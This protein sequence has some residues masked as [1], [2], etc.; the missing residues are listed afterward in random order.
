MPLDLDSLNEKQRAAV[1][2]LDGPLLVLAGAGSGKTRTLTYR[3]AYLLEQGRASPHSILAITFTRKAAAELAHRLES[4]VGESAKDITA[5]TFHGLGYRLLRAEAHVFG[6]K[7]D[8][9]TVYDATDARR[10]LL[11]AMKDTNVAGERWDLEMVAQTISSAKEQLRSPEEFITTEGDFFEE[12]VGKVY[13][14]YQDLLKENNAVDY[15]DLIRLTLSLLQQRPEA[16]AFYQNLFRYVS[17]DELQDTSAAQYELVRYLGWAHH[18]VCAVGSPMQAIYS[19][20]GGN[21]ANILTRFQQD[22]EGAPVI[23]LDQNYRSTATILDAANSIAAEFD[24]LDKEMWTASARGEPI[25]LVMLNSERDEATFIAHEAQRLVDEQTH[26]F[27][28]CAVLFR[29]KAQGR[30]FEQVLMEQGVPYTLVGDFRFFERREIKDA[31]AYLRVVHNME[32]SVAL[33]RI[34]NRPP[35]GLGSAALQKLQDGD[36][37]FTF[38]CLGGVSNRQDLPPK[39]K[40][41]ALA[42]AELLFE[43]LY[44][45][46]REKPL[47]EFLQYTIMAS[48]YLDWVAKDP[49]SKQRFANLHTLRQMTARYAEW[50]AAG[51]AHFL[52]EIATLTDADVGEGERGITLITM[53][54]A[55]GLEFP[56]VFLAGMEDGLFP[57]IKS[58]RTPSQLAEERRLAYVAITRAMKRLYLTHARSRSMWGEIRDTRLSRFVADIPSSLIEKRTGSVKVNEV[59]SVPTEISVI[60]PALEATPA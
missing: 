12:S 26:T 52:S 30:V 57:H 50:G 32:D 15:A 13:Q 58:T 33:Q 17:V 4:L 20:R 18:N 42:F 29:T 5:T 47:S 34:I 25:A 16:L 55:K 23:V 19:W 46:S 56:I 11:R 9:L 39:V 36:A 31:L 8:S 24:Y 54:A 53:H 6:Y 22:F 49:E 51:L 48:G 7:P 35:R 10:V 37:E 60:A 59:T 40:Q 21:I 41:A 45:A 3:L 38:A 1:E 2:H 14:R 28:D 27:G 43:D 44:H